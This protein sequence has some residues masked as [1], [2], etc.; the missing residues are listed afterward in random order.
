MDLPPPPPVVDVARQARIETV[1]QEGS[2]S[3]P[4]FNIVALVV[5]AIALFFLYKR[6]KDKQETTRVHMLRPSPVIPKPAVEVAEVEEKE[7]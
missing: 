1:I 2:G 3:S 5:I 4:L 7:E 6:Y